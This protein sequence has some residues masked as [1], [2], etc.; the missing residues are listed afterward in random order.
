[1]KNL[2]NDHTP[3]EDSWEKI[4]AKMSFDNQLEGH[5]P[6]LPMFE[7]SAESWEKINAKLEGKKS[8]TFW[9]YLG[10][11]AGLISIL[12]ISK[13]AWNNVDIVEIPISDRNSLTEITIIDMPIQM[14]FQV[15]SKPEIAKTIS[16]YSKP[17]KITEPLKEELPE[18]SIEVPNFEFIAIGTPLI[19][20]EVKNYSEEF[21]NQNQTKTLHEVTISWGFESTKFQVKTT[22][23]KSDPVNLEEK[24]IGRSGRSGRIRFGQNN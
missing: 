18:I 14:K 2:P 17:K 12:L 16:S 1:M 7:P 4:L 10:L 8:T 24:Q 9:P 20:P 23:G 6:N 3:K 22:F 13:F 11:A 15:E 21:E 19:V 5:I